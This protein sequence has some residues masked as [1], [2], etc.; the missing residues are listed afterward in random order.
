MTQHV[1]TTLD[2]GVLIVSLQRPEKKNA[3]TSKMYSAM[4]AFLEKR[5]PNFKQFD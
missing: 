3:L 4:A 2:D 1:A 5:P